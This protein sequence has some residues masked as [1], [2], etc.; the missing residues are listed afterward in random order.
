MQLELDPR[1]HLAYDVNTATLDHRLMLS[2]GHSQ[3]QQL[4]WFHIGNGDIIAM[5][6]FDIFHNPRLHHLDHAALIARF[7][8][9]RAGLLWSH[10]LSAPSLLYWLWQRSNLLIISLTALLLLLLWRHIPRRGVVLEQHHIHAVNFTDHLH[11][12][13]E[14]LW[15]TG[16]QQALLVALRQDVLRRQPAWKET[17]GADND[18][19]SQSEAESF[20]QREWAMQGVPKNREEL[21]SIIALLQSLR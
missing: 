16:Q 3:G 20:T 13:G 14:L 18:S 21:R 9:G 4:L 8:E 17:L 5:S 7:A 19:D 11:A 10:N 1:H 2:A 15:R 12:S 6:D